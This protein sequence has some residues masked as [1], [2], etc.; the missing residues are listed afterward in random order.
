[1]LGEDRILT[2]AAFFQKN[3]KYTLNNVPSARAKADAIDN[4]TELVS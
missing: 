1:M 3:C 4:F 2:M